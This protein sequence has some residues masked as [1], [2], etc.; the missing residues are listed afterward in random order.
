MD[1]FSMTGM[2]YAFDLQLM[3][4]RGTVDGLDPDWE[5]FIEA[6]P[7]MPLVKMSRALVAAVAGE[8]EL[9]RAEFAPFR[10]LPDRYPVGP[11]WAGTMG[12]VAVVA[13]LLEDAE[14]AGRVYPLLRPVAHYYSGDGSG[15]V[16]SHGATARLVADMARV[17]GH[18]DDALRYYADAVAMNDRI[19]SRP[20]SALSRLGWARTLVA[21]NEDLPTAAELAG[22]AAADLRRLDL[23]GQ[24]VCAERVLADIDRRR[25][26]SSPLSS[27]EVEIARLVAEALSNRQIADRLVL[28]ERTV[29]SH[30]RN[31]LTKLG[32]ATRTEI[33]TWVLRREREVGSRS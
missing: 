31:I 3:V 20:F 13:N 25:A 6:G 28:S 7:P 23:A 19:G 8:H 26:A 16:F 10:D 22:A 4:M 17:A 24:V 5:R 21:R 14:V 11:R 12:Q 18:F 33:A 32:F 1:D 9:A 15:G 30:V 29:E 2:Y 27:R